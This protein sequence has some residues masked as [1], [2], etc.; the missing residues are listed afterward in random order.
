MS[1]SHHYISSFCTQQVMQLC[2][3]RKVAKPVAVRLACLLLSSNCRW[4]KDFAGHQAYDAVAP[5]RFVAHAGDA[6]RESTCYAGAHFY[7]LDICTLP[8][9]STCQHVVVAA[10]PQ[11]WLLTDHFGYSLQVVA[12]YGPTTCLSH[13]APPTLWV[14]AGAAAAWV[15]QVATAGS[16]A[17]AP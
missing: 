9:T 10:P 5:L 7:V 4:F 16:S 8:L 14:W 13:P 17:P 3:G 6:Q 11:Q 2:S 12:W 1:H 15:Q